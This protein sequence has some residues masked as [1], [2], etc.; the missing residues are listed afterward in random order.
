LMRLVLPPKDSALR[1]H[2]FYLGSDS[3]K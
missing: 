3:N 1:V 2:F